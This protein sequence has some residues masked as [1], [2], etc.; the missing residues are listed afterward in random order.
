MSSQPTSAF[1]PAGIWVE[2]ADIGN[3]NL[4]AP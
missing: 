2:P 1:E 4:P 3:D